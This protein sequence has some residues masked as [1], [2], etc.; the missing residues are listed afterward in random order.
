MSE[1]YYSANP[2]VKSD[3]RTIQC[4][5]RDREFTFT[6]DA[7]VFS[8]GG[9]DFGTR[10][11]IETVK[12]PDDAFVVDLGCGYGPVG[13]VLAETF[14]TTHWLL[15]DINL[16][17]VELAQHNTAR[18]SG[19][20]EVRQSDGLQALAG[21]RPDAILLN[22]PIRAGKQ[23]VYRLFAESA[24]VLA[25]RGQ[26]WIVL[27]KKHGADSGERFLAEHFSDVQRV[28][29]KSGYQIYRCQ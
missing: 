5:V 26:L 27:H 4:H 18:W 14:P 29:R 20:I 11:L 17:A 19:R 10:L 25:G 6:V 16:R 21:K 22:P 28:A 2:S 8:K 9:L 12:L 7:G 15:L 3:V 23:V 1:H 24:D 13:A